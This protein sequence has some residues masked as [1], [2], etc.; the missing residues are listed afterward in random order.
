M[1]KTTVFDIMAKKEKEQEMLFTRLYMHLPP[2]GGRN[3][4]FLGEQGGKMGV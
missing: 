3:I 2:F 1:L 4:L